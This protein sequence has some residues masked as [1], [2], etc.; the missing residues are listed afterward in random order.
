MTPDS[1]RVLVIAAHPDDELLGCG[2]TVARHVR[3]GDCVTSVI[4][5]E[6]ESLRYGPNGVGQGSHIQAAARRLGVQDIRL[7]GFPDQGLDT[8]NLTDIIGAI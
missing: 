5:C 2:G 4:V 3:A 8:I 6:G 7:L 1:K